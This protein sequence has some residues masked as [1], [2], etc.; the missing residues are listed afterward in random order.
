MLK[1]LVS[2]LVL[3]AT[4]ASCAATS[5][6]RPYLGEANPTPATKLYPGQSLDEVEEIL[7]KPSGVTKDKYNDDRECRSYGYGAGGLVKYM[8]VN[9][10][11]QVVEEYS[12][13]H[14]GSECFIQ[15]RMEDV[16]KSLEGVR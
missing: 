5:D 8:R 13:G 4:L 3:S 1:S 10:D 6:P 12:D 7:G 15:P 2:S 9:Y 11:Q 14:A 16:Q